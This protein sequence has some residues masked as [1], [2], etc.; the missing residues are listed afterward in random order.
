MSPFPP[1]FGFLYILIAVDYVSKWVEA[2]PCR[3]SDHKSVIKFLKENI[4]TR[5]FGDVYQMMRE[6][7]S[8]SFVTHKRV[9]VIFLQRK[10]L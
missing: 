6:V 3:N 4:L 8:L 9:A 5:F 10:P 1:S 7:V 2:I